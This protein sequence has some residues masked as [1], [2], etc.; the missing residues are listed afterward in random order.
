MSLELFMKIMTWLGILGVPSF[1]T[2]IIWAVSYFRK[3]ARNLK[4]LMEAQQA[5]M[6]GEL[7]KDYHFFKKHGRIAVGV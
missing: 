6:R 4:I 3:S 1:F 7:L 5:Q 2:I